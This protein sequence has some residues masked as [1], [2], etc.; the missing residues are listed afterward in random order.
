MPD[1]AL[2]ARALDF[3]EDNLKE[4]IGVADMADAVGYSLYHFSRTFNQATH[5]TPYDYLMRRRLSE[6]ARV[7]L[8]TDE[9]IIDVALDYQFNNPETFSRAFKRMFETQPSQSR[10]DGCLDSRWLMPR[11]T[12]AHLEQIA[13]GPYL[14]PVLEERDAFQVVGLTTLVKG[15]R[16]VIADL[17]DLL[18]QELANCAGPGVAGDCYG[19]A[20]YPEGWEDRGYLYMAAVEIQGADT[21]DT[22][23]V[24]K[25][26]PV[27]T[28]ARFIHKGPRHELPLT[29]HYVHHTWLPKSGRSPSHPLIIECYGRD[30]RAADRDDSEIGVYL[31]IEA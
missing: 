30:F 21:G 3:I 25:T 22:A 17:W 23:L 29:L 18:H 20:W 14:R 19:L 28:C 6:A 7:L 27:L 5:H 2:I 12:L 9:R 1:L 4:P 24:T 26:I 11:L 8:Q 31:P 10:R 15:D 13:K 16:S